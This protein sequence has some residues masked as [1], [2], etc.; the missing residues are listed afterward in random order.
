MAS[1]RRAAQADLKALVVL[2]TRLFAADAGRHDPLVDTTWPQRSGAADFGS[3][4]D[5]ERAMVLVA[6]D[7]SGVCGHLVESHCLHGRCRGR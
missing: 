3:L 7:P 5:N 2:E 6:A 4:L 1:I